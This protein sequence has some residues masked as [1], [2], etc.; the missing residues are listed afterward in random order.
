MKAILVNVCIVA[1]VNLAVHGHANEILDAWWPE[2]GN[3]LVAQGVPESEA[4]RIFLNMDDIDVFADG[5][6]TWVY[7]FSN[8]G[9]IYRRR[10]QE[11]ELTGDRDAVLL[12]YRRANALY[13]AARW[14]ALF[15]PA[16]EAAYRRQIETY[17]K[18]MKHSR[19]AMEVVEVPFEGRKIVGHFYPTAN[20]PAPVI[21]WS[22]GTDGWKMSDLDFKQTLVGEGFSVFAMD[23][24]GTGESEHD[25]GPNSDRVYDRVVEH[26]R[27]RDE[28][29][30]EAIAVYSGSFSGVFAVHLALTNPH[31]A[32][33]VNHSGGIHKTFTQ[34]RESGTQAL[35]PLTMSM[36]MRAVATINAFGLDVRT[37]LARPPGEEH[38]ALARVESMSLVNQ[39]LLRD[40]P[41]QAPLLSIYGTA[42]MLMPIA[43]WEILTESGV[44]S[45]GLI[46]EGARHM[47]WEHAAAHRPKMIAWLKE[48][49]GMT[50]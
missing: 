49:L 20:L 31:V 34:F 11:A 9:D 17:L 29:A 42:D 12:A 41:D 22:G 18:I 37:G 23:M 5:P 6:G 40:A 44:R 3:G 4:R 36:G 19:I 25:L 28:V 38:P 7:E 47:A 10:A 2:V 8:A 45:E 15:T 35:P 32:A 16:K 1:G 21:V 24:P 26:L 39:G 46:Y 14:P 43:D 33:A 48:H 50:D 13:N 30:A 27:T